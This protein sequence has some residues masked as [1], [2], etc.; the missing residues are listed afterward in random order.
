MRAALT[1][2]AHTP[3]QTIVFAS[4]NRGKLAE[5]QRLSAP[6]N[7]ATTA[8]R[9][10]DLRAAPEPY[11]TV[12][13]NALTTARHASAVSGLPA[14]ADD[15]GICV[16]ALNIAPGVLSAR[17]AAQQI[18]NGALE[19][20]VQVQLEGLDADAANNALLLHQMQGVTQRRACFVALLVHV[21]HPDDPLP[22][23]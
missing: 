7:L 16:D 20:D 4:N 15:S 22:L 3:D 11:G 13:D 17:Y 8:Q 21:R 23:R 6:L 5:L 12:L 14:L 19:A 10:S 18:A 9:Q 2:S 1:K